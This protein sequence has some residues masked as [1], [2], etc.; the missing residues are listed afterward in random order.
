MMN[1]QNFAVGDKIT[2]VYNGKW[3]VGT[4]ERVE[5]TYVVVRTSE[6]YRSFKYN[7]MYNVKTVEMA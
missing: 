5:L 1:A 6:G 3:R 4:V 7:K 2:C